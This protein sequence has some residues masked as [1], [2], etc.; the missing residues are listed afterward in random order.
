MTAWSSD[1]GEGKPTNWKQKLS[2]L[3][4]KPRPIIESI[5]EIQTLK[6]SC[7]YKPQTDAKQPSWIISI[8][9]QGNEKEQEKFVNK[10]LW[11]FPDVCHIFV[12]FLSLY[13]YEAHTGTGKIISLRGT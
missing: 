7:V 3:H 6:K 2:P 11:L 8:S 13:W 5:Q 1:F 9:P 12:N 10:L 4:I